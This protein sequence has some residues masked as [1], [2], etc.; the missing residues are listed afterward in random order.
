[1]IYLLLI[2]SIVIFIFQQS[3][4]S[5]TAFS[6]I[7]SNNLRLISRQLSA[8]KKINNFV[9]HHVK[10]IIKNNKLN[11]TQDNT[12]VWSNAFNFN[13]SSGTEV[14]PRTGILTAHFNVGNLLSNFGHGPDIHLQVNYNSFAVSDP[15]GL[16]HGWSWNLT[17][18]NPITD[19][20]TT[21]FGQA[22][23]LQPVGYYHW[24][25]LYHK[26]KDIKIDGD[27]STHF[28][29]T[30]ANGLRETL[31]HEGYIS[32]LEQQ[33][34]YTVHF[35]YEP[36]THLLNT[37]VDDMGHKM[38]IIR[39][40][41]YWNI[42]SYNINGQF[43]A[44]R[45]DNRHHHINEII[46]PSDHHQSIFTFIHLNYTYGY[47]LSSVEY[48]SGM[49]K[50]IIYN[51]SDAMKFASYSQTGTKSLC[52]VSHESVSPGA[53]QPEMKM[54]YYYTM[55]NNKHNYLGFNAGISSFSGI[56]RDSLFEAPVS[57]TYHTI[58]DNGLVKEIRTW[59]KYHLLINI[60]LISDYTGRLLSE[61]NSYFCRTDSP[62]ACSHTSFSDLPL[63]Y[64]L[65]LKIVTRVWGEDKSSPATDTQTTV[66]DDYGRVINHKDAYGRVTTTRY[67]PVKGNGV[68]CPSISPGWFFSRLPQTVT[69]YPVSG[70]NLPVVTRHNFY[71]KLINLHGAGY[72]LVLHRQTL[73][74]NS[75]WTTQT[76]NY[77]ESPADVLSYGLLKTITLTGNTGLSSPLTS[78]VHN[79][80][81]VK[82]SDNYSETIYSTISLGAKKFQPLPTLTTSLFTH[83]KLMYSDVTGQN[84]TRYHYDMSGYLLQTDLAVGTAFATSVHYRY[85]L[86][87]Q[88]NY[89]II[90]SANGLKSKI[91]FDGLGRQLMSFNEAVSATGKVRQGL[92]QA[93]SR[94]SYDAY[95]RVKQQASFIEG[96]DGKTTALITT[97]EYDETGRELQIHLPGSKTA[98]TVYDDADR[99]MVSYLQSHSG[100]R[101]ALSVI[102]ANV[103]NKPVLKQIFPASKVM[104]A[105]AKQL[106]HFKTKSVQARETHFFYDGFG[107]PIKVIDTMGRVVKK[108]YDAIGRITDI[109]N[110]KQDIIHLQYNLLG[111]VIARWA[112]PEA[113]GRYLLYAARYNEAGQLLWK[114]GEDSIKSWFTYTPAGQVETITTA[115]KHKVSLQYNSIGLP[116]A[117]YL[118][119]HLLQKI[120]YNPVTTLPVAKI[121]VT[122]KTTLTYSVD[123][124]PVQLVHTGKNG[125]PN[126]HL[127]WKYDNNRRVI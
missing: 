98:V 11:A 24:Q 34:G 1:M 126:Y 44:T 53:G 58:K 31:S 26:L 81:Y 4:Y 28:I 125:Y 5:A 82:S 115:T 19:Q 100:L 45:I 16:G 90:T 121:D 101:S 89:I 99:C 77:Y 119:G 74:A 39:K 116:I 124:L 40:R 52:V 95:G 14:D 8:Y 7:K 57:Y 17:H 104:P 123:H 85:T 25:P 117:K 20:L 64:S 33:D 22:F 36:G 111:K 2:L 109:V 59:N 97:K 75:L 10:S 50:A 56:K 49:K 21:S 55:A 103:L 105:N 118:D 48:P 3:C 6:Q 88:H 54:N 62:D 69:I 42:N 13:K 23:Y 65:P 38:T 112:L 106:C 12:P 80:R 41:G 37:I 73:R 46:L 66:Y 18:F 61:V 122:G 67:C 9:N 78:V 32:L 86:S 87:P 108:Y 51:C 29:I 15:D 72:M 47:L 91:T 63:T 107:R 93:K 70:S 30:Y 120:L 27:K 43:I 114:S 113:G 102:H 79:Y 71:R 92:W 35:L 60:R 68:A 83:Q 94:I 96:A 110:P 127:F 84:I 76:R